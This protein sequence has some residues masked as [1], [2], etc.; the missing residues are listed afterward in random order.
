MASRFRDIW[1]GLIES[2]N[3]QLLQIFSIMRL[4]SLV[5]FRN[6]GRSRNYSVK[7]S[8]KGHRSFVYSEGRNRLTA[9]LEQGSSDCWREC[10][11]LIEPIH[12]PFAKCDA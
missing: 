6:T 2:L 9:V 10:K 12:H 8:S 7:S 5:Q 11:A 1:R 3:P 4:I